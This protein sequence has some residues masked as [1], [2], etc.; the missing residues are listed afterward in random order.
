MQTCQT[1]RPGRTGGKCGPPSLVPLDS[2]WGGRRWT[3]SIGSKPQ[4]AG[5]MSA[6]TSRLML[7][8]AW[9]SRPQPSEGPVL[10]RTDRDRIGVAARSAA[11][12]RPAQRRSPFE[13]VLGVLTLGPGEPRS[14]SGPVAPE[15]SKHPR[16]LMAEHSTSTKSS[17]KQRSAATRSRRNGASPSGSSSRSSPDATTRA[18][19]SRK[20]AAAPRAAK[21][22]VNSQSKQAKASGSKSSQPKST[23]KRSN[24][25][26]ARRRAKPGA[27][28]AAKP[29]SDSALQRSERRRRSTGSVG[30]ITRTVARRA[31]KPA[32]AGGAAVAVIAGSAAAGKALKPKRRTINIGR[33]VGR[34]CVSSHRRCPTCVRSQPA[35]RQRVTPSAVPASC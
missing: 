32:V 21:Q 31:A 5:D 2:D 28:T 6:P 18:T 12:A 19:R 25:S 30:S 24:A 27:A 34:R 35:C 23:S 15:R 22:L 9:G 1:G 17:S 20:A 14:A 7:G 33:L 11:S 3:D 10:L 26:P 8:C 16:R 4:A 13:I 29:S